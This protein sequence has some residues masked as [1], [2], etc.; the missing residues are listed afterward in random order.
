[1][2]KSNKNNKK[3]ASWSSSQI[4]RLYRL[5]KVKI[6]TSARQLEMEKLRAYLRLMEKRKHSLQRK[7][8]AQ[9]SQTHHAASQLRQL[10]K[11]MDQSLQQS[12]K[13]KSINDKDLQALHELEVKR[14]KLLSELRN[15]KKG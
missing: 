12:G 1:M 9:V 3:N 15:M 7:I 10:K 11:K 4:E 13:L 8:A 2:E 5:E 6:E 14:K